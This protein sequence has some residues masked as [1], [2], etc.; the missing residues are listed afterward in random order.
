MA[1]NFFIKFLKMLENRDFFV[2]S[3]NCFM[4]CNLMIS[5]LYFRQFFYPFPFIQYEYTLRSYGE[6]PV[7]SFLKIQLSNII[8]TILI[9]IENPP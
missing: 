9:Y 8:R 1:L 2:G 6:R 4:L 7:K 5:F 3:G